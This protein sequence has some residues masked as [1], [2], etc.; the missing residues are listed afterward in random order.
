MF[1]IE[2]A[3]MVELGEGEHIESQELIADGIK[4][5]VAGEEETTQ[6]ET[7]VEEEN[8]EDVGTMSTDDD[9]IDVGV[10]RK[11]GQR[12]RKPGSGRVRYCRDSFKNMLLTIPGIYQLKIPG[13]YQLKIPGVC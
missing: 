11:Q 8:V 5:F 6:M 2:L 12:G 9:D 13:I 7:R 4:E 1:S 3:G 10:K